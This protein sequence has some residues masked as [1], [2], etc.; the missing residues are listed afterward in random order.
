MRVRCMSEIESK[1]RR[2]FT[3]LIYGPLAASNYLLYKNF[4]IGI[5]LKCTGSQNCLEK[6]SLGLF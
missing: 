2:V 1:D 4:K 6:C 5:Y 3:V